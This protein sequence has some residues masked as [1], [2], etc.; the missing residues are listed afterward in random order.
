MNTRVLNEIK[1]A[2]KN[3]DN[4]RKDVFKSVRDKALATAKDAKIDIPTDE[5]Y[6]AAFLKEYK[7]HNQAL[8]ELSKSNNDDYKNSDFYKITMAKIE[9]LTPFI[10]KQMNKDEV[11]SAIQNI[12]KNVPDTTPR[13]KIQGMIMKELNGKADKDL[14]VTCCKEIL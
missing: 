5:M 6:N 14:L 1:N 2:M 13:G 11:V 4:L 8:K 12:I 7:Q 9:I 10:P 3:K